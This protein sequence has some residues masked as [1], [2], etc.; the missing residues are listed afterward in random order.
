MAPPQQRPLDSADTVAH[1][2]D[3]TLLADSEAARESRSEDEEDPAPP[4]IDGYEILSELGRGGMGVVYL[5]RQQGLK[6]HVALKML[7][8]SAAQLEERQR[9]AAEA[10]AVARIQHP[11]IVNVFEVGEAEG[12]PYLS[13][14]YVEGGSLDERLAGRPMAWRDAAELMVKLAEAV[15]CAHEHGVVHRDLKPANILLA[16]DGTPKITDFGI[17]KRLDQVRQTQTGKILGTPTYMAPEQGL[18]H[19]DKVG[20]CTDIYALGAMLYDALTGRPPFDADNTMDTIVQM[21]TLEPVSPRQLQPT[22]PRDLEVICLKCLEKDPERRYPNAHELAL[23]LQRLLR[24]EPIKARPIGSMERLRRWARRRPAAAA[25]ALASVVALG[26]LVGLWIWF[27]RELADELRATELARRDATVA[28]QELREQLLRSIAQRI[29][30]D[31]RQLSHVPRSVAAA[32]SERSDWTNEQLSAWLKA[33]LNNEPHIFGMAVAFEPKQFS[34]QVD[35]YSLYVFRQGGGLAEKQLLPPEYTPIYREWAWYRSAT[36]RGHWSEPYVDDGGGDIPMVTFSVVFTR[37]AGV[38]AGVVTADLSLAYFDALSQLL[39]STRFSGQSHGFVT[40]QRGVRVSHPQ[41]SQRFP[42]PGAQI[43]KPTDPFAA[44]T[45]T[46]IMSGQFG[47]VTDS[48]LVTDTPAELIF[49]P[50]PSANW[51]VV[52][53]LQ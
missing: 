23:D 13:L 40:T 9:F 18:G 33:Q 36:E 17:A 12:R 7:H 24:H 38:P 29:D 26:A 44:G 11:N 8:G 42:A 52:A 3:D 28:H 21:L 6:R 4:A 37:E 49:A 1:S 25:L 48:T 14:E 35:D 2:A 39:E 5:A 19:N 53:V 22:V 47:R 46:N 15:H 31:L 45:W 30:G 43:P 34:A 51:S 10:E 50:I 32:L 41:P 16:E 20:P 27:T